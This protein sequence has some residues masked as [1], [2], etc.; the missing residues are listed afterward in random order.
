MLFNLWHIDCINIYIGNKRPKEGSI[1]KTFRLLTSLLVLGFMLAAGPAMAGQVKTGTGYGPY[2]TGSGGEF[3]LEALSADMLL[4]LNNGYGYV[5]GVTMNLPNTA[6]NT[7]QTFCLEGS[8]YIYANN[9]KY[10]V[11]ISN[12]A[13]GDPISLGTAWVYREFATGGLSVYGYNYANP[14]RSTW[15]ANLAPSAGQLQNTIWW[16]EGEDIGYNS[17]NLFMNAVV[18]EFG[19]ASAAMADANGAYGVG[20]LN[21]TLL[22]GNRA[23]DQLVLTTQVPEPT[24]LLLLGI[25]LVGVAIA[26]RRFKVQA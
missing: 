22:N 10:N 8:E 13:A 2:Q 21:M 26:A 11:Q 4:V 18:N 19:S 20:V 24:A 6:A 7:F 12:R 5:N 3:T 25:G 1:V 23:Q 14:G 17:N 16:L 15:N 9:T